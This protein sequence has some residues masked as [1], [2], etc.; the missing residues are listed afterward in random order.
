MIAKRDLQHC[1]GMTFLYPSKLSESVGISNAGRIKR[2]G[3]KNRYN[4]CSHG[5]KN[6]YIYIKAGY[7]T[8]ATSGVFG[9][10]EAL[11][12]FFLRLN[13]YILL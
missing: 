3:A 7:K 4:T 1:P 8:H 13:N 5:A 9:P 6:R 12:L 2:E 11:N 10:W